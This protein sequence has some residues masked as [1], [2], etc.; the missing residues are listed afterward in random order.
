MPRS[1]KGVLEDVR[2]LQA[3]ATDSPTK[4]RLKGIERYIVSQSRKVEHERRR[5]KVEL[6]ALQA[7]LQDELIS[8]EATAARIAEKQRIALTTPSEWVLPNALQARDRATTSTSLIEVAVRSLDFHS[9]KNIG[10][11]T[12]VVADVQAHP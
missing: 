1:T 3:A 11:T 8:R 10:E 9:L 2:A 5:G 6:R 12:A 7:E 4:A